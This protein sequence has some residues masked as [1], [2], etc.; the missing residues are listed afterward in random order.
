MVA[1]K[2]GAVV[3]GAVVVEIKGK[4]AVFGRHP[5]AALG[6]AVV[7]QIEIDALRFGFGQGS[8]AVAVEIEHDGGVVFDNILA[9]E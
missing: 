9:V 7:V 1:E 3:D 4:K 6:K 2:F 5:A 8:D